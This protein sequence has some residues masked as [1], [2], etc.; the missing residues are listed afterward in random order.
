MRWGT[1]LKDLKEFI[2]YFSCRKLVDNRQK[3]VENH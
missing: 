1:V 2:V 3:P